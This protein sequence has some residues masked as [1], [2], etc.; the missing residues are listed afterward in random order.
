MVHHNAVQRGI[1]FGPF[2]FF[3][4]KFPVFRDRERQ[5]EESATD[6]D[7]PSLNED[8]KR[9]HPVKTDPVAL[10]KQRIFVA[11][12]QISRRVGAE[13]PDPSSEDSRKGRLEIDGGFKDFFVAFRI[14]FQRSLIWLEIGIS[15]RIKDIVPVGL[16]SSL[17]R[18]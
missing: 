12:R 10:F 9:S 13:T 4:G 16:F 7:V 17:Q 3:A 14:Q 18:G 1:S 8:R 5:S 15:L 11:N 2:P 6:F